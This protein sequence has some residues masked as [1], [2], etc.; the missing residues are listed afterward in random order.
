MTP[1]DSKIPVVAIDG[2]AGTGKTTV[3]RCVAVRLGFAFL[4]S[5]AMY[6]AAT[7]RVINSGISLDDTEAIIRSTHAMQLC[8][9]GGNVFVDGRDVTSAIRTP[10]VTRTIRALDGIP[11]VRARLGALQR[12]IGTSQPTV[13]EGRDMGT[14]VFPDAVCKIYLDADLEERARRRAKELVRQGAPGTVDDVKADIRA[15]DENDR[16]REEAPLRAAENA[17]RIDTTGMTF[18][19]VVERVVTL[20]QDALGAA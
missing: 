14:V 11:E 12:E 18:E 10:E 1:T 4:D 2:P 7:W 20:A 9:R 3:A 5:G 8:M 15:R 13:A 16:N 6:R 19:E 17:H